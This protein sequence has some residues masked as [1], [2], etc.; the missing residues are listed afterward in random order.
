MELVRSLPLRMMLAG[1]TI[2]QA[3]NIHAPHDPLPEERHFIGIGQG[4]D[5]SIDC[6]YPS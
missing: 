2:L 1:L 6:M 3:L 4:R 5:T